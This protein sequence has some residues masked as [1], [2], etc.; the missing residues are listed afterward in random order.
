MNLS[1]VIPVHNEK[2]NLHSLFPELNE[3]LETLDLE[4]EIIVVNDG[5]TDG[6]E[7]I[8]DHL[9][10]TD[11]RLRI[12]HLNKNFGQSSA[13]MAGFDYASGDVIVAMDG[14]NQNDP[15]DIPRLLEKMKEGYA[16][17]SGWRK[18]RKEPTIRKLVPSRIAN[19]LISKI[20]GVRLHDY[21]CSL[22]A[23][24]KE[25]IK[26]IKIYGETHR[27]IPIFSSWHGA[28]IT[29]IPVG[30]RPRKHGVSHYGISRV[31]KVVLDIILIK[32]LEKYLQH[33]I[34]FFGGFGLISLLLGLGSFALM[35]YYKYRGGKTFIETPLP[36][37]TILF[38]LMGAMAVFIGLLA[39][40]IMRT[41]YESQQKTTYQI[42]RTKNINI[43]V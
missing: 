8:L 39:E 26:G 4:F 28:T 38:I 23:Y 37:L 11:H 2:D 9:A 22:K 20:S 25:V 10:E 27:F 31:R 29:E 41:Y 6:S 5:S 34:H 12:L 7:R 17:V 19:W 33:P 36:T 16:V 43:G 35:V 30:H 1:V 21:G 13:M 40:I 24:R 14:D 42:S 3:V 15:S 18:G 32:F